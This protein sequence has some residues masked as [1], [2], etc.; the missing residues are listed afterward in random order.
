MDLSSRRFAKHQQF[1]SVAFDK[2]SMDN[3]FRSTYLQCR[4]KSVNNAKITS[5]TH[6]QL[7]SF[8]I[9]QSDREAQYRR[10]VIKDYN[11]AINN[12]YELNGQ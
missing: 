3:M 1:L 10:G 8:I 4:K 11:Y 2:V 6:E 5:V 12:G 7:K 9:E